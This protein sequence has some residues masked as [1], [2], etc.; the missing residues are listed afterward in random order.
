MNNRHNGLILISALLILVIG[1]AF[2]GVS[3]ADLVDPVE[4]KTY[5]FTVEFS[6]DVEQ[7][8]QRYSYLLRDYGYS[9]PD[10]QREL[11][12]LRPN[13]EY[14][15]YGPI[16]T[17]TF[18]VEMEYGDIDEFVLSLREQGVT[19]ETIQDLETE[20]QNEWQ[21]L[22][23][24][25]PIT[26]GCKTRI[27]GVEVKN[28]YG[29]LLYSYSSYIYWCYNGNTITYLDPWESYS[30]YMG[31]QFIGS[32]KNQSGG[33]GQGAYILHRYAIFYNP[34]IGYAYPDTHQG[35]YGDGTSW[36]YASP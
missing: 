34:I 1:A 21:E 26:R 36:G 4:A 13:L 19:E 2:I 24:G 3:K 7:D 35:V 17:L 20:V 9:E 5:S 31:W 32:T 18:S 23:T 12:N 29:M 27:D 25:D 10:I 33:L 8:L 22:P 15:T 28:A 11:A 14:S 16:E 30:T 6:G